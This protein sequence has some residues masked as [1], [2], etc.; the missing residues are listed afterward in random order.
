[1][2]NARKVLARRGF[3]AGALAAPFLAGCSGPTRI[4]IGGR[5]AYT[6]P[7]P[8]IDEIY[9]T[10]LLEAVTDLAT[11]LAHAETHGDFPAFLTGPL[12]TH[13]RALRTGALRHP[14][15]QFMARRIRSHKP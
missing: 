15:A 8:G 7:P 4:A 11:N 9:R 14:R 3:L 6:P 2:R 5:E 12:E 13:Q 1:M 10:E